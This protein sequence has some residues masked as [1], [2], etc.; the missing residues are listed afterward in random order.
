[1]YLFYTYV[2]VFIT[3][4]LI[5][6]VNSSIVHSKRNVKEKI[7]DEDQCKEVKVICNSLNDT[8]DLSVLECLLSLNNPSRVSLSEECQ[9]TVWEHTRRLLENENVNGLLLPVCQDNFKKINCDVKNNGNYFKCILNNMDN[10]QVK[11]CRQLILRLEGVAFTDFSWISKFLEH[12]TED[13]NALKCGR[14]DS[15]SF[16]QIKTLTCLQNNIFNIKDKCEKEILHLSR[17]QSDN[18]K[19]DSELYLDCG[20]DHMRYCSQFFAGSG[21]VFSCLMLQMHENRTKLETKC[22]QHLLRRQKLIAQD[23]MVS[24]GLLRA[25]KEDI[26][27]VHCQKPIAEEKTVRL[28]QIL[29]CLENAAKNGTK[30]DTNC[31]DE[32]FNHRRMLMEDYRLSPEIVNSCKIEISEFCNGIEAGGKTI[33]CLMK[34]TL[35]KT[36]NH[37]NIQI[38]D[39]CMRALEDLVKET[40]VGENWSVDPVLH[41]ACSPIVKVACRGLQGG[42]AKIMSCLLDKL[43]TDFMTEDCETALIQIQYFVARDFRLDPQLYRECKRDARK[44]CHVDDNIQEG[45]SYSHEVLP[46]LYRHAYLP[47]GD[48]KLEKTCLQQIRRVMRQRAINVDLQPEIEEA[49]LNDLGSLCTDKLKRGEEMQCLQSNLDELE[50]NCQDAVKYF[51]E[52]EAQHIDLNPYITKYCSRVIEDFCKVNTD[53]DEGNIMDCLIKNKNIPQVKSNH[54]CFASIEHF[55]IISLKDYRFS[56]KFK[57]ACKTHA[58]RLCSHARSK[59]EVV[60][61]L[62]ENLLNATLHDIQCLKNK[63]DQQ[64]LTPNCKNKLKE[65]F[66]MYKN[67]LEVAPYR[68]FEICFNRL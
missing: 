56:Y 24:R 49:C 4:L 27:K 54:A 25:C 23:F 41:E 53:D 59:T 57:V 14:I 64:R 28:A 22:L 45:P 65:R 44:Y 60:A 33:H 15:Q 31:K 67:A 43:G 61:C 10:I 63:M 58:I 29:L 2:L 62:S 55:Q 12:C 13:I 50:E 38:Q 26:K 1:M 18:I 5:S 11:D 66:Q 8:D 51:T 47:Q 7:F 40:D 42:D 68:M 37:L 35:R 3:F 17:L 32:I 6:T 21:R 20:K 30:I 46:C 52:I 19:L 36:G 16:S 39:K 34:H 9:H 48:M